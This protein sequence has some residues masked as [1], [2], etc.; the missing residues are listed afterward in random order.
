MPRS[1]RRRC[2][3][4]GAVGEGLYSGTDF[5]LDAEETRL[6]YQVLE[7]NL[8]LEWASEYSSG[9]DGLSEHNVD[10]TKNVGHDIPC[11]DDGLGKR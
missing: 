8:W 2:L 1:M 5:S 7:R 11:G 3:H 4:G 10:G 9:G 6:Q